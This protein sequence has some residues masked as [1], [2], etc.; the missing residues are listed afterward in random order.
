VTRDS[1][2]R[3]RSR[4]PEHTS[5]G[6]GHGILDGHLFRAALVFPN[7]SNPARGALRSTGLNF[8]GFSRPIA[9]AELSNIP[10]LPRSCQDG[11]DEIP[12]DSPSYAG[13]GIASCHGGRIHGDADR[14]DLECAE[15]DDMGSHLP[16]RLDPQGAHLEQPVLFAAELRKSFTQFR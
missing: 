5:A 14:G 1:E 6:R 12:V 7:R 13:S 11:N 2:S 3:N 8:E 9:F 10:P 16:H 15:R 4:G